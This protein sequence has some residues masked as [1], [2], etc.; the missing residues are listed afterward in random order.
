MI[1]M[2]V[3]PQH[4]F[5]ARDELVYV[6]GRIQGSI[7]AHAIILRQSP[8]GAAPG[9]RSIES[10]SDRDTVRAPIER[11]RDGHLPLARM[12][13]VDRFVDGAIENVPDAHADWN[14]PRDR[15][16]RPQAFQA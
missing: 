8:E 11:R 5:I 6:A 12:T 13:C 14:A 4:P 3:S 16:K 7:W 10:D 1:D 2:P 9:A 15:E